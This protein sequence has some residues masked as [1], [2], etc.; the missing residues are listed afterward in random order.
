M[1]YLI[2]WIREQCSFA[3]YNWLSLNK[4]DLIKVSFYPPKCLNNILI[5]KKLFLLRVYVTFTVKLSNKLIFL[6]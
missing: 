2:S 4:S 3:K 6:L 5:S 1:T